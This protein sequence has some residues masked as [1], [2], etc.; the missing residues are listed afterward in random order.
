MLFDVGDVVV[1]NAGQ[2]VA[3]VPLVNGVTAVG[4]AGAKGDVPFV[5][6]GVVVRPVREDLVVVADR[7]AAVDAVAV[8]V[9]RSFAD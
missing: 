4:D 6:V 7:P 1:G 3:V 8:V 9:G 2:T 5:V